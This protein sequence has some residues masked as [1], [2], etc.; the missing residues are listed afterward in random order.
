MSKAIYLIDP[1]HGGIVDGKYVTPGKR[2]PKFEDG[3]QLFEGVYNRDVAKKLV[4]KLIAAN[5]DHYVVVP[6][7]RDM[8]LQERV[9]LANNKVKSL[10]KKGVYISIHG[11]AAGDGIEFHPAS[12]IS[13]FTSKGQTD[14]D[15]FA[16]IM[17]SNLKKV[18]G[19]EIKWR[20]DDTDGDPD[21]EENFYVL[22]NTIMSAVLIESGFFTNKEECKKMLGDKWKDDVALSIFNSILEWEKLIV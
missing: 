9:N 13:V 14:S 12:G 1:G 6:D 15:V 10:N 4:A 2:S 7:N 20:T 18:F 19:S 5:I 8:P 22:K 16:S 17:I 3:T 21:K 11:D